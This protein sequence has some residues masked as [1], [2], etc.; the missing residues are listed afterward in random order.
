MMVNWIV[1]AIIAGLAAAAMSASVMVP[2]VIS[3]ILFYLASLPLFMASLGWGPVAGVVGGITGAAVLGI[4]LGINPALFFLIS[5]AVAPVALSRLALI[6]RPAPDTSSNEGE[7]SD[8][9]VEWY[10]EG[11]LVLWCAGLAIALMT[12]IVLIAGPD[13]ESFRATVSQQIEHAFTEVSKQIPD[14]DKK[15]LDQIASMLVV[16]LP[17]AAGAIWL[18]TTLFNLWAAGRLLT[19]S[20][21]SLRP[22]APFYK[23]AFP[24][25]ALMALG[26]SIL[27]AFVP[28]VIGLIAGIAAAVFAVAFTVLGLAVI[29]SL[30]LGNPMRLFMLASLYTILLVMGW[31][32]IVPIAGLGILDMF[33]GI[34]ARVRQT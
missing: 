32:L 15:Q 23:L 19:V 29:H 6:S 11:R 13:A 21:K 1:V 3:L 10:P 28:G 12:A 18:L 5:S 24:R 17:P 31:V 4:S 22:W 8:Q 9:G 7:A 30:T 26:G 16:L 25:A 27:L 34:R 33:L 20:G 2:S 14:M